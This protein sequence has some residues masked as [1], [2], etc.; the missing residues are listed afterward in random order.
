MVE[1]DG[2]YEGEDWFIK[3]P[4]L[5]HTQT[6]LKKSMKQLIISSRYETVNKRMKIFSILK[7]EFH[8]GI[9]KHSSVFRAV[10][11]IT[12]LIIENGSPLFDV[13]YYDDT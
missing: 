2:G 1:A 10:G 5:K 8:H 7:H 11:V 6:K 12:Q 9:K 3:T 13:K 4:L